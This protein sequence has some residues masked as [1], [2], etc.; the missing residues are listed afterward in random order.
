MFVKALETLITQPYHI[1]HA[2]I[3]LKTKTKCNLKFFTKVTL[4]SGTYYFLVQ[5]F[6]AIKIEA[7]STKKTLCYCREGA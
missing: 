6:N 3:K 1:K 4:V 2:I 5:I 7:Y